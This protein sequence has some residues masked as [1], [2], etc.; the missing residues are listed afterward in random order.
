MFQFPSISIS[1][2]WDQFGRHVG[3]IWMLAYVLHEEL[4]MYWKDM[5][6]VLERS[7]SVSK[8]FS[9][10]LRT[11]IYNVHAERIL[12]STR[13]RLTLVTLLKLSSSG[14]APASS[15]LVWTYG[16]LVCCLPSSYI[17]LCRVGPGRHPG[18]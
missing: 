12:S 6:L 5:H 18:L 11:Y 10:P 9:P 4:R 8:A 1:I 7:C 17:F 13:L 2:S 3:P 14:W 15:W 16:C